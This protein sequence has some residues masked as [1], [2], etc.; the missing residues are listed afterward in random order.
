MVAVPTSG[1]VAG[2]AQLDVDAGQAR[3]GAVLDAVVGGA[4]AGAVVVEQAV[5]DGGEERRAG[6]LYTWTR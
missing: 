5:A 1:V 2:Q 4:A 6:K 3:L